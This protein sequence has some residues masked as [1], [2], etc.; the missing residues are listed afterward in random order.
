[1]DPVTDVVYKVV[2]Y[3]RRKKG[4][5]QADAEAAAIESGDLVRDADGNLVPK[6]KKTRGIMNQ[7]ERTQLDE[8]E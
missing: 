6:K 4:L 7:N 1:M 3:Y 8:L 2:A 5:S